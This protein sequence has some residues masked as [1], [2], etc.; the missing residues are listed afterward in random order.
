MLK[1]LGQVWINNQVEH[2]R[3]QCIAFEDAA[4]FSSQLQCSDKRAC[5]VGLHEPYEHLRQWYTEKSLDIENHP[6]KKMTVPAVFPRLSFNSVRKSSG[7]GEVH[8][9]NWRSS[10]TPALLQFGS[11]LSSVFFKRQ[12]RM[13]TFW[14][15]PNIKYIERNNLNDPLFLFLL[16]T[17]LKNN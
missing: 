11:S 9:Q 1:S 3:K 8:S 16:Q 5:C 12:F 10:W 4:W 13:R 2:L 15:W 14:V 7:H 6:R 17:V